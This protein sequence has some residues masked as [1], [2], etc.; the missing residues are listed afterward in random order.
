LSYH[1]LQVIVEMQH[2]TRDMTEPTYVTSTTVS[3][4]LPLAR[5]RRVPMRAVAPILTIAGLVAVWE[6]WVRLGDVKSFVMPP[7][8]DAAKAMYTD[9][10]L[11]LPDLWVTVREMLIGLGLSIGIGIPLAIL[12]VTFRWVEYS[13]YPLLVASQVVPKLAIAPL[14]LIWFGFGWLPKSLLV[15]SIC[16]FPIVIDTT[17]GLRKIE[18]EKLFLASSMGAGKLTTFLRFRFPQALP[19]IFTGLK[20]AGTFAVIGAIVAEFV[21]ADEGI[22]HRMILADANLDT[23]TMFAAIGYVTILGIGLFMLTDALERALIPWHVS[24]RDAAVGTA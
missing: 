5:D 20:L 2:R 15:L 8:S 22:G 3:P 13:L 4:G 16:F 7:A 12:I 10:H 23:T 21:G 11:L 18:R 17:L 6:V 24:H 14:F 1:S 9:A 19:E